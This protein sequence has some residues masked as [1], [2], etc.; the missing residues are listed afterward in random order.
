MEGGWV[1]GAMGEVKRDSNWDLSEEKARRSARN[2]GWD[3][4]AGSGEGWGGESVGF[5]RADLVKLS[6]MNWCMTRRASRQAA[7]WCF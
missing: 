1:E 7:V 5:L 3:E 6:R 2:S 4:S